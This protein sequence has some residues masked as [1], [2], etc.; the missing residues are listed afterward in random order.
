MFVD[1][2]ILY[3]HNYS[4]SIGHQKHIPIYEM[5]ASVLQLAT[6]WPGLA[7]L[8][9]LWNEANSMPRDVVVVAI[10][11]KRLS[12][13]WELVAF[14]EY[15]HSNHQLK[16]WDLQ[17]WTIHTTV[18]SMSNWCR[19]E[20]YFISFCNIIC[21]KALQMICCIICLIDSSCFWHISHKYYFIHMVMIWI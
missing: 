13:L 5:Y 8:L 16:M 14:R 10:S 6:M 15:Q 3:L 20:D 21:P 2:I 1:L 12:G 18:L 4:Q 19:S 9:P 7:S 17:W 11:E